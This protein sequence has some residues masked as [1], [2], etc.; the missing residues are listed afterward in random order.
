MWTHAINIQ[1]KKISLIMNNTIKRVSKGILYLDHKKMNI[2]ILRN[3]N[4]SELR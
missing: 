2:P 4:I 1:D 3:F